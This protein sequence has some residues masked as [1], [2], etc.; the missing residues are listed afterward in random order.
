MMVGLFE[1]RAAAWHPE[2][3]PAGVVV[4]HAPARLGPDGPVPGDGDVARAG[5]AG[6]RR[7]HVLLRARVV[8]ARPVAD[9]RRGAGHPRVLRGRRHELRRRA[10]GRR[11]RPGRRAVDRGRQ[12]RR[13]RDRLRRRP[14]PRVPGRG[15]VPGHADHRDP[16]HRVRRPHARQAAV[17]RPR[18][19]ALARAR[20]AG[21]QRRLP[22]RGLRLGGRRLVRRTGRDPGGDAHVGARRLVPALGGRAPRRARGRRAD[23]H[24]VHDQAPRH[25][26]RRGAGARP[27]LGR[28]RRRRGRADHL[29][30][31]ARRRTASSRPTSPSPSSPTTTSGW[32]PRTPRTGTCSPGWRATSAAPTSR[33]RT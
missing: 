21:G 7:P 11:P 17:L 16:R 30:P 27:R 3:V 22:A 8:H 26:C 10:V 20:P 6:G 25:R 9:R 1:P 33:S 15:V 2:G 18:R 19:Q 24:V 5:D 12:A 28:R 23:G 31:V 13:R 4:H 29:H 14:V 32:S